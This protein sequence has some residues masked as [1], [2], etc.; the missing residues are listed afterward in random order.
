VELDALE[1]WAG[2]LRIDFDQAGRPSGRGWQAEAEPIYLVCTHGK[3]DACCAKRGLPLFAALNELGP[4]R[5]WQSTHLGGHRFA[6]TFTALPAGTSY[7]RIPADG[8]PSL[9]EAIE[10]GGLG[11]TGLLRGRCDLQR[12]EQVAFGHLLRQLG[13][14]ASSSSSALQLEAREGRAQRWRLGDRRFEVECALTE[15]LTLL[16]SCSDDA[17]KAVERWSVR[18]FAEL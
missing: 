14:A 13:E 5:V 6:P 1:A 15:P 2:E 17:P 9:F 12:D 10:A 8:V 4:G 16:A 3:R 11:D 18:R 7:G